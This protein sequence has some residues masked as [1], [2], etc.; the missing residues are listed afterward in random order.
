MDYLWLC[1][2]RKKPKISVFLKL[3][4]FKKKNGQNNELKRL[5]QSLCMIKL[6]A[7]LFVQVTMFRFPGQIY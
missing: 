4:L 2:F 1:D 3:L 7:D 6:S 5:F